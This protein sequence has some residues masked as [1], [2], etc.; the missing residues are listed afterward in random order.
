[1]DTGA[2]DA[3]L[4]SLWD[5]LFHAEI[6]DAS[7]VNPWRGEVLF[8]LEANRELLQRSETLQTELLSWLDIEH[9]S[10][11]LEARTVTPLD[12]IPQAG[13]LLPADPP[14][15]V[16]LISPGRDGELLWYHLGAQAWR[17]EV[18][19]P[20]A[21]E[22]DDC[23]LKWVELRFARTHDALEYSPGLIE[24]EVVLQPL[25]GF[26]LQRQEV[27]LPLANGLIGLGDDRYVIKHVRRMHIAA[28]V[29]AQSTTV[30]FID[31]TL[32]PD[33]SAVWGFDVIDGSPQ[34]AL[35][36]AHRLN[37][38]PVLTLSRQP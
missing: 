30:D 4:R 34:E 17:L 6:S 14:L 21:Q 22:C 36:H 27:Y 16:E 25:D 24:D 2:V 5:L 28:R 35:H 31:E 37:I 32:P 23:D 18:H 7:G 8:A 20:A 26:D 33:H 19:L 11:D 3:E 9:A 1:M 10:V 13:P 29:S 12:A 38:V 15:E